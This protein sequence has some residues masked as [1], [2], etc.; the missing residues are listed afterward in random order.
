MAAEATTVW[1][2]LLAPGRLVLVAAPQRQATGFLQELTHEA[3]HGHPGAVLWC[4]GSH[5]FNPAEFAE[6]NMVRGRMA[7]DG[8]TRV[9]VKRCMTPFQW[10]STLSQHLGAKLA[11]AEASLAVVHPFDALWRHEEIQDWEQ[12][13]YTRF[14]VRHLKALARQ[15]RVPIVL[16]VDVDALWRTHP[17]LARITVDGVDDRWSVAGAPG[18][19]TARRSD[20]A[21]LGPSRSEGVTLLDFLPAAERSVLPAAVPRPRRSRRKAAAMRGPFRTRIVHLGPVH[22]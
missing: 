3:V 11:Q 18:R 13:D 21:T 15:H 16:G 1:Q 4:D 12:E 19:W 2:P 9:L 17:A 22:Q 6:L 8:A 14:S 20:G 5:T 7:D 10:H